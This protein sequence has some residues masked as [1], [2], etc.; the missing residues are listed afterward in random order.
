MTAD[1]EMPGSDLDIMRDVY[2]TATQRAAFDRIAAAARR[3][4]PS[5]DRELVAE[6]L[7]AAAQRNSYLFSVDAIRAQADLLRAADNADAA[8]VHTA[9][10]ADT[11]RAIIEA[12]ERRG[13][14]RARAEQPEAGE[15]VGAVLELAARIRREGDLASR[16]GQLA[17]LYDIAD[18]LEA[19]LGQ[20]K[21]NER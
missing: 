18:D 20:G 10:L 5:Y 13:Y 21:A 4:E 14:E 16:S 8:G 9:R 3:G 15:A 12:A 1:I 17:R 7:E 19:A 6:M 11:Q 2:M